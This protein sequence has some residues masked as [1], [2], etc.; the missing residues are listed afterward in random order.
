MFVCDYII[1]EINSWALPFFMILRNC[2]IVT[3][4]IL[5][6]AVPITLFLN[7]TTISKY[8]LHPY[9]QTIFFNLY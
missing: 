9:K 1:L 6:L 3:L 7:T 4:K 5:K 8:L 2:D